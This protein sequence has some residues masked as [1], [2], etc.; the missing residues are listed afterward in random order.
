MCMCCLV[1][2]P[3]QISY[4]FTTPLP[5]KLVNLTWAHWRVV[6][7]YLQSPL[8][9]ARISACQP[10][11]TPY[12]PPPNT[13]VG[14][15]VCQM[16]C[17]I[18]DGVHVDYFLRTSGRGVK[19]CFFVL[20]H[21]VQGRV[22]VGMSPLVCNQS[23]IEMLSQNRGW[24]DFSNGGDRG[25]A[26]SV[27]VSSRDIL[28]PIKLNACCHQQRMSSFFSRYRWQGRGTVKNK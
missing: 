24:T 10:A 28:W 7:M 11:S 27:S 3:I 22:G 25:G 21:T 4:F 9:I 17:S 5:Y 16:G 2:S 19:A 20:W 8:H 15:P 13:S 1:I 18:N 26:M 6:C 12:P 23:N 14:L